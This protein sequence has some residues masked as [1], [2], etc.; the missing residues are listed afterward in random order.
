MPTH[1]VHR[2][3]FDLDTGSRQQ[4]L[5]VQ[6]AMSRFASETLPAILDQCLNGLVADDRVLVVDRLDLDLG[7]LVEDRLEADLPAKLARAI[8]DALFVARYGRAG[9]MSD[10]A[11]AI[12]VHEHQGERLRRFLDHGLFEAPPES[13][14]AE[15]PDELVESLLAN[16]PAFA[17]LLQD[18]WRDRRSARRRLVT[19]LSQA[20]L[21]R[22]AGALSEP[23]SATFILF[24]KA[25][26]AAVC[27]PSAAS[28]PVARM[29]E[30]VFDI[31]FE[32]EIKTFS[33]ERLI[34]HGVEAIAMASKSAPADIAGAI[35]AALL[36][37]H[38]ADAETVNL[39][40]LLSRGA[41]SKGSPQGLSDVAD[42]L[43][44]DRPL[45]TDT[46]ALFISSPKP[47]DVAEDAV[48]AVHDRESLFDAAP[49]AI[50]S[51]LTNS[52][53]TRNAAIAILAEAPP[54]RLRDLLLALVP[55]YAG[56]IES[57][58]RVCA[59]VEI[60]AFSTDGL[61]YR[62]LWQHA[63]ALLLERRGRRLD[64]NLFVL[65]FSRFLARRK[66]V[67]QNAYLGRI[68][69]LAQDWSDRE[70]RYAPLVDI[71]QSLYGEVVPF[72][73][74]T[75]QEVGID[76][77]EPRISDGPLSSSEASAS[78]R[79]VLRESGSG[80]RD[81]SARSA[82]GG[83]E[84]R[85]IQ[86]SNDDRASS[87]DGS[88][89]QH[90]NAR[91]AARSGIGQANGDTT[92]S[93]EG[94]TSAQADAS[95]L[96]P[97]ES[98]VWA[99][100]GNAVG[101]KD[102][103]VSVS[104]DRQ[105]TRPDFV[106][107]ARARGGYVPPIVDDASGRP[108]SSI[109]SLQIEASE[110]HPQA[111]I[112]NPD[113]TER[114]ATQSHP[115]DAGES[116][117]Q[118]GGERD[119]GGPHQ[120]DIEERNRSDFRERGASASR[121]Q[122][123]GSIVSNGKTIGARA[124]LTGEGESYIG[125]PMRLTQEADGPESVYARLRHAFHR[126]DRDDVLPEDA[127]RLGD[128][129]AAETPATSV[130]NDDVVDQPPLTTVPIQER[131]RA[132][133]APTDLA[134]L[135]HYW[136]DHGLLPP[137]ADVVA[138][139]AEL[140]TWIAREPNNIRHVIL[141]AAHN[142][143]S[144]RNLI[145]FQSPALLQKITGLLV[146]E[147]QGSALTFASDV[148]RGGGLKPSGAG[149]LYRSLLQNLFRTRTAAPSV[150]IEAVLH[151]LAAAEGQSAESLLVAWRFA[152]ARLVP[153]SPVSLRLLQSLDVTRAVNGPRPSQAA[154]EIGSLFDRLTQN[155]VD[156]AAL[157]RPAP[158]QLSTYVDNAGI[159]LLAP[160]LGTLFG[161]LSLLKDGLFGSG[162]EQGIGINLLQYLASG[163]GETR[164]YRLSLH[165]VLCGLE[166]SEPLPEARDLTDFERETCDGLLSAV[167]QSWTPLKN[168]SVATLREAFL[169][170][171]GRLV[172]DAEQWVLKV[173]AKPYD[174]LLDSLPWQFKL[175]K[176]RWMLSPLRVDWR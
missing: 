135:L 88:T 58:L 156:K 7:T 107:T 100:R 169:Q 1:V 48:A 21:F 80:V 163:A 65:E 167:T 11:R 74:A 14:L 116:G 137:G 6:D 3:H 66:S 52:P 24:V 152:I 30:L 132:E 39:V 77:L 46:K 93:F 151:E 10:G 89:S 54:D 84:A 44:A 158:S 64:V 71:V 63:F 29:W 119:L 16:A 60:R 19:Q 150:L 51:A 20:A 8:A 18:W 126:G 85:A 69:R 96:G 35:R 26:K 73:E 140:E 45:A 43:Y 162:L 142:H 23:H 143:V 38:A 153:S 59:D 90:A 32:A 147:D 56:L 104:A 22:I 79:A 120:A 144:A 105:D 67:A 129:S 37:G 166:L 97:S 57:I 15:T 141:Q 76:R 33:A 136:L 31:L 168:S 110:A 103:N 173:A 145:L 115:P 42:G 118:H 49:D 9:G 127:H 157:A 170:R 165:K 133:Q 25:L 28:L 164:E 62:A 114:N 68:E 61:P 117:R 94:S 75:P 128:D 12:S 161:R 108:E 41:V 40:S 13:S 95:K 17:D 86:S 91:G 130:P 121:S 82:F 70:P 124:H 109:E 176:L 36:H 112:P 131:E 81:I 99:D 87:L 101:S 134:R 27:T 102:S 139:E 111:D 83:A 174:M 159:V 113:P 50:I 53:Q 72:S 155:A 47:A 34:A 146:P 160:Y 122:Q 148:I 149:P 92:D 106:G 171:E 4:A 125:E 55:A 98:D 78:Q 2:L 5:R 123:G 138:F 172:E 175:I 154:P